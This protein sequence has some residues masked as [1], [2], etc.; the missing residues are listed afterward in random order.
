MT[1]IIRETLL[2]LDSLELS[3]QDEIT[4]R[5]PTNP[6]TLGTSHSVLIR[7]VAPFQGGIVLDTWTPSSPATQQFKVS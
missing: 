2:D 6:A 7:G 5:T 3:S 4:T 1:V